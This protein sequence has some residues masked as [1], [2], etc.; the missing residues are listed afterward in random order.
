[1][2][3]VAPF[4]A[5]PCPST[6]WDRPRYLWV[7]R[8]SGLGP[9]YGLI[10]LD[11]TNVTP[12]SSLSGITDAHRPRV[13]GQ[14]VSK[15][16][17]VGGQL[18][19][20]I[21]FLDG[22]PISSRS[23]IE[24]RRLVRFRV[25]RHDAWMASE[26]DTTR[27]IHTIDGLRG[28]AAVIVVIHH[29]LLISPLLADE[30]IHAP[31]SDNLAIRALVDTPLHL[32][33]GGRE[34]VTVFFVLSG[35]ALTLPLLSGRPASWLAYYPRRLV[36]LYIPVWAAV[37]FAIVLFVVVH[38]TTV[39][40]GSW[41]LN[42][43]TGPL[44]LSAILYDLTLVR[45][46]TFIN[47]PLWSLRWEVL[48]SL[49]LPLYFY[50]AHKIGRGII[51]AGVIT[52]ILMVGISAGELIGNSYLRYLPVFGFGV[53]LSVNKDQ[54]QKILARLSPLAS[55]ALM[56]VAIVALSVRPFP[57]VSALGG[58]VI[59]ALVAWRV[60]YAVLG[61]NRAIV[62][63]GKISFSL[64]LVHEPILVTIAFAL[65]QPNAAIVLAAG[66][67]ISLCGA[68]AFCRAVEGPA[69]NLSRKVG[70][71]VAMKAAPRD[72]RRRDVH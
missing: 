3:P 52:L 14:P 49:L 28:I 60:E 59:V 64:Y 26:V 56:A 18:N 24:P 21:H 71:A 25:L 70:R 2:S 67:P 6:S 43:L 48:F 1:M 51:G 17:L 9:G 44:T 47:S 20:V 42:A 72:P 63:L 54:I 66:L 31:V 38:R 69:T 23:F 27:R 57:A 37:A 34:A 30:Y 32:L 22:R 8:Q 4:S 68:W 13:R 16:G 41:W 33:W 36:R 29:A 11:P 39:E 19:E 58:A 40:G 5:W 53:L 46:T 7:H 12:V 65:P 62:W 55:W 61:E 15:T 10:V 45:G 35:M 50:L